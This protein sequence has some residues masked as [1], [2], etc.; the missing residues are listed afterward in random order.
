MLIENIK[1]RLTH[2]KP[3]V[4][5]KPGI[6]FVDDAVWAEF[7]T[8]KFGKILINEGDLRV[9]EGSQSPTT[10]S[11]HDMQLGAEGLP[12]AQHPAASALAGYSEKEAIKNVKGTY[13][14]SLLD[15]WSTTETRRAVI[16]AIEK[17]LDKLKPTQ[18]T[19]E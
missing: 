19:E 1:P 6:S 18:A 5:L 13:D 14:R 4:M 8:T 17:Q 3:G 10:S 12:D 16:E 9:V 15:A 11:S 7:A 2:I